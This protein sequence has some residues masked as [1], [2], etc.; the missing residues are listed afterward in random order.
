MEIRR[1]TT[2][3]EAEVL[4]LY[5]SVGWTVYADNPA[6]VKAALAGSLL[7]LGAFVQDELIG[8]IR[9]V[10]DGASILYIQDIL[11]APEHQRKGVGRRLLQAML[12]QYPSIY[13]TVLMTD[14]IPERAAFYRACGFTAVADMGCCA[15]IRMP[16][17]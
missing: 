5:R 14:N 3:H 11:V 6:M 8:C 1:Y 13:Q 15:F 10:G 4:S 16:G 17:R 9:A 12:A 7:V 2:Y